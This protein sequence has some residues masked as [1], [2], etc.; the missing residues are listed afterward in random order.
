VELTLGLALGI[1]GNI[2]LTLGEAH[3]GIL[4]PGAHA[5]L[6]ATLGS[7]DDRT[8]GVELTMGLTLGNFLETWG[9]C[10]VKRV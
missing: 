3:V 9:S 2:G 4:G 1:S 6:G 8:I 10:L 7:G 5:W